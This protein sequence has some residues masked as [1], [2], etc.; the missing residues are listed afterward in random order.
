MARPAHRDLGCGTTGEACPDVAFGPYAFG[1]YELDAARRTL[2]CGGAERHLQAKPLDLLLYL[3]AHSERVVSQSELLDALWPG[4]HVGPSAL[5]RAVYKLRRA[6]GAAE[7]P[8]R[9]IATVH[10]RGFR[11]VAP[12]R[13]ARAPERTGAFPG[14]SVA[15]DVELAR[16]AL[17]RA[18]RVLGDLHAADAPTLSFLGSLARELCGLFVSTLGARRPLEW[19]GGGATPPGAAR[20]GRYP[21]GATP[22]ARGT[23]CRSDRAS[24]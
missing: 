17:E 13:G 4:V 11:F 24:S 3:I 22:L 20:A 1:P 6:L 15:R 12:L 5:A 23:H 19:R 10:G 18:V 16:R 7:G 14:D 9:V 2:T 8:H 21:P